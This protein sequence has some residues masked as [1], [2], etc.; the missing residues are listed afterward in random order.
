[1]FHRPDPPLVIV[2]PRAKREIVAEDVAHFKDGAG[3]RDDLRREAD[4]RFG[5]T[6]RE[7]VEPRVRLVLHRAKLVVRCAKRIFRRADL[8]AN[9]VDAS[10]RGADLVPNLAK[11][12]DRD[13]RRLHKALFEYGAHGQQARGQERAR[14]ISPTYAMVGVSGTVAAPSQDRFWHPSRIP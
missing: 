6:S 8:V 1:M 12:F 14:T 7:R 13:V 3:Y 4:L 9:S 2:D 10:V 11:K 5:L